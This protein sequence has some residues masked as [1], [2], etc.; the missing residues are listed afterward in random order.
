MIATM[1]SIKGCT[2]RNRWT[3]NFNGKVR[4]N[5]EEKFTETPRRKTRN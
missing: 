3:R 4:E 2:L 1:S 5:K